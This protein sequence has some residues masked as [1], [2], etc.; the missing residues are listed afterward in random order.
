[1]SVVGKLIFR[2]MSS[3]RTHLVK[4]VYL[5]QTHLGTVCVLKELQQLLHPDRERR[6]A[7]LGRREL[8][9]G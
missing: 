6:G 9:H 3:L 4:I 5:L 7:V 8:G 1:M 2:L